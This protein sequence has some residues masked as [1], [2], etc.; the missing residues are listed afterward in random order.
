MSELKVLVIGIASSLASL[1]ASPYRIENGIPL[2]VERTIC[3]K[4]DMVN[5]IDQNEP[6]NL[7]GHPIGRYR[8]NDASG[9]SYCTG[10]LIDKDLF[11]TANHC[12]GKCS[13]ITVEFGYL[14]ST[15]VE[16][17]PCQEIVESGGNDYN[18]D[19][20][21]IRLKGNPGVRWGWHTPSDK[22]L[23]S[24]APLL[25]IHH[26]MATPMKVSMNNCAFV[27]EQDGLLSHRCDTES[28]SSGSALLAP[29]FDHPE[30]TRIVGVHTLGGCN[31]SE[32]SF[33]SG[34][35]MRFL[36]K[37]SETLRVHA[38]P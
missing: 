28:G 24:E 26:P 38:K 4:N 18:D 25:M 2:G 31:S 15:R 27:E 10:T 13:G 22:P 36:V 17:F 30:N 29:D 35:S 6:L 21:I 5:M 3:G 33:N 37:L 14:A 34:P 16:V 32:T 20:F 11:L 12:A 8:S 7:M 19:Y 9:T 23:D 1:L